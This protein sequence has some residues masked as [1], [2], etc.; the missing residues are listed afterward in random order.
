MQDARECLIGALYCFGKI[1]EGYPEEMRAALTQ[2]VSNKWK[3]WKGEKNRICK[4]ESL[5]LKK[6]RDDS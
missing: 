4:A 1:R 2:I 3:R 5:V 6:P